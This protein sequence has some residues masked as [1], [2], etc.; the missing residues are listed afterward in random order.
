MN[1]PADYEGSRKQRCYRIV[2]WRVVLI[3]EGDYI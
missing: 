1:G 3:E 2:G